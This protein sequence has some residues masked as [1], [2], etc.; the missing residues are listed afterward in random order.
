M[1]FDTASETS[2][3]T[4]KSVKTAVIIRL[5]LNGINQESALPAV[6]K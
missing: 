6:Q 4:V 5:G 3:C 1:T 2:L